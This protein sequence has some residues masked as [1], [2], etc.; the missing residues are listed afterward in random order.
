MLMRFIII[1]IIIIIIIVWDNEFLVL[2]ENGRRRTGTTK[3]LDKHTVSYIKLSTHKKKRMRGCWVAVIDKVG[4]EQPIN[5][6]VEAVSRK[7]NKRANKWHITACQ[8]C[9]GRA[10][11]NLTTTDLKNCTTR[12]LFPFCLWAGGSDHMSLCRMTHH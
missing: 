1:I 3:C 2:C 7:W 6:Q 4:P 5:N 12:A 11:T 9:S 8:I 10:V